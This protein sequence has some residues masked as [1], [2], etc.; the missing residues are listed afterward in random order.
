MPWIFHPFCPWLLLLIWIANYAIPSPPLETSVLTH[1]RYFAE[2]TGNKGTFLRWLAEVRGSE[3]D[4]GAVFLPRKS[5][6]WCWPQ[7]KTLSLW[8]S[9][10][11][12]WLVILFIALKKK[13]NYNW[14]PVE[15]G[16]WLIK[17]KIVKLY[18]KVRQLWLNQFYIFWWYWEKIYFML[19]ILR[20]GH[21]I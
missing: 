2:S 1:P 12:F 16:L 5:M 8:I 4:L 13:K 7:M 17:L 11:A 15:S 10:V 19:W 14:N 18:C 21:I 6:S 20:D 3:F 9:T